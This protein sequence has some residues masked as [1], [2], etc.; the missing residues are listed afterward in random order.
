MGRPIQ[1]YFAWG[2]SGSGG[3]FIKT[4]GYDLAGD[5]TYYENGDW[6]AFYSTF[7]GAGQVTQIT[8]AP[9]GS[10]WTPR[11]Y[12]ASGIFPMEECNL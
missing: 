12:R 2:C 5:Q 1:N 9:T 7:N 11:W 4:A 6:R 3:Y 8:T 10:R